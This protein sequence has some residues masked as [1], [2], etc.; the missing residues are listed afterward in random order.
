MTQNL[1]RR[2]NG[3]QNKGDEVYII[4]GKRLSSWFSLEEYEM[5]T[6]YSIPFIFSFPFIYS[7]KELSDNVMSNA[8]NIALKIGIIYFFM[9]LHPRWK[10]SYQINNYI[11]NF[12]ILYDKPA[13]KNSVV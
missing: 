10:S 7:T 1:E 9:K 2:I 3:G 11:I 13:Q 5:A 8:G 4:C 6:E 12:L